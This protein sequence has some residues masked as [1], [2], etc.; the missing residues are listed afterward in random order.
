MKQSQ[1]EL[2]KNIFIYIK[3]EKDFT[4]TKMYNDLNIVTSA[5]KTTASSF[6]QKLQSWE[7]VNA[8]NTKEEGTKYL[9]CE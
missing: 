9:Y 1:E 6:L 7:Y 2:K 4:R 5:Q 3:K 8:Y